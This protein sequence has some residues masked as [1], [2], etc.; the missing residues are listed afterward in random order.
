MFPPAKLIALLRAGLRYGIVKKIARE[1]NS[2]V[3]ALLLEIGF[4]AALTIKR[5]QKNQRLTSY[6]SDCLYRAYRLQV[7]AKE[8]FGDAAAASAWLFRD[9][10]SIRWVT[11]PLSRSSVS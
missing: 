10:R 11:P 4:D 8:T 3:E 7:L 6:E 1:F 9:I 5:L 2:P